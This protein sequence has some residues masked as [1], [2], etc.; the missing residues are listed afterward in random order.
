MRRFTDERGTEWRVFEMHSTSLSESS[1]HSLPAHW[2]EGW[3]VFENGEERRRLAPIPAQWEELPEDR[4]RE[5][6][7]SG[8][9]A[10]TPISGLT[11]VSS[12][13]QPSGKRGA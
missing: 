2:R 3:L 4:M 9:R 12:K 6:C 8:V 5:L 13:A 10:T 1:R 11:P 7:D